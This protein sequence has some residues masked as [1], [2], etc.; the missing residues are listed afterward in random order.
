M[1]IPPTRTR[2]IGH[3]AAR[4][5]VAVRFARHFLASVVVRAC[6]ALR[7]AATF[8]HCGIQTAGFGNADAVVAPNVLGGADY[9]AQGDIPRRARG[10]GST[11]SAVITC[12]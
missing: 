12:G 6:R 9:P 1:T 4:Y 10:T 8:E 2:L 7:D 3:A 5:R 11:R